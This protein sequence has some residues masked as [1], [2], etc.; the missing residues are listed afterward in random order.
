MRSALDAPV[1]AAISPVRDAELL[2]E[3]VLFMSGYASF[4][5]CHHTSLWC[6]HEASP[7]LEISGGPQLGHGDTEIRGEFPAIKLS[8]ILLRA[9]RPEYSAKVAHNLPRND[10]GRGRGFKSLLLHQP[11]SRLSD[12]SEN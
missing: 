5:D 4:A 1:N 2:A 9:S 3:N 11:V 6:A 12:I 8:A 7:E 10:W